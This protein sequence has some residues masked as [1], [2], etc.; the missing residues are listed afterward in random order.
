MP[1]IMQFL[2]R[3]IFHGWAGYFEMDVSLHRE[4]SIFVFYSALKIHRI[5]AA[6]SVRLINSRWEK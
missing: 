2:P 6:L 4:T 5:S 1:M 3:F